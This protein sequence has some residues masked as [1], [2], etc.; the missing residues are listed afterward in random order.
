MPAE[1]IIEVWGDSVRVRGLVPMHD[2][3][4]INMLAK[5]NGYDILD[6][7][8]GRHY[9]VNLFFTSKEFSKQLQKELH[10]KENP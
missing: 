7:L 10:G 9:D 8:L 5:T 6:L 1:Y 4:A 3:K 2:L